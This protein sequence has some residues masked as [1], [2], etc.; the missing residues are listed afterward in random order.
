[1]LFGWK[2]QSP[3]GAGAT[4]WVCSLPCSV[5]RLCGRTAVTLAAAAQLAVGGEK[6]AGRWGCP[7]GSRLVKVTGPGL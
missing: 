2:G 3:P 4:L 6:G 5:P 1:M 7:L